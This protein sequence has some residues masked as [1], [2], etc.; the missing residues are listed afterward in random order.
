MKRKGARLLRGNFPT[1]NIFHKMLKAIPR[2][3]KKEQRYN[4]AV[5]IVGDR[6]T[7]RETI[8]GRGWG[9]KW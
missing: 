9:G 2:K 8:I 4:P 1:V 5:Y 3:Q 6:A 7:N